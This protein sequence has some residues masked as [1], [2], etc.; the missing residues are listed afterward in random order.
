MMVHT[1]AIDLSRRKGICVVERRE[2]IVER[3]AVRS[4]KRIIEDETAMVGE[5]ERRCSGVD[6]GCTVYHKNQH[7]LL[8]EVRRQLPD[9]F[10]DYT[11]G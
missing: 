10:D 1:A 11:E 6:S 5:R 7:S 9:Y 4:A 3:R 2:R 8:V